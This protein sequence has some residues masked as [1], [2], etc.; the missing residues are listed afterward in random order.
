MRTR[1]LRTL[2]FCAIGALSLTS[3][4]MASSTELAAEPG[5][6]VDFV[7]TV[8]APRS[9][10]LSVPPQIVSPDALAE[11]A[12]ADRASPEPALAV[13]QDQSL[14]VLVERAFEGIEIDLFDD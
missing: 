3:A 5:T 7:L 4:A 1:Q 6:E 12:D 9:E 8:T 14:D 10:A 13:I 2:A 11:S